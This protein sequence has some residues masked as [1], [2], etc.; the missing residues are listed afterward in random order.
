M[1]IK[2]AEDLIL[3]MAKHKKYNNNKTY[4]ELER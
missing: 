2:H 1:L 4:K 3:G